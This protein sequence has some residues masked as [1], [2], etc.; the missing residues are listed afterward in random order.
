M[1]IFTECFAGTFD[2]IFWQEAKRIFEMKLKRNLYQIVA[3]RGGNLHQELLKK[4]HVWK[5]LSLRKSISSHATNLPTVICCCRYPDQFSHPRHSINRSLIDFLLSTSKQINFTCWT[6]NR[7][8][9][10]NDIDTSTPTAELETLKTIL[11]H[12]TRRRS[13]GKE[14]RR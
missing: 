3:L 14:M 2:E 6:Y 9:R 12:L 8:F 5:S 11:E 1:E 4:R 13:W 7:R 10:W